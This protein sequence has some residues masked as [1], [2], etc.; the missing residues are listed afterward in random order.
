MGQV[1]RVAGRQRGNAR[2][3]ARVAEQREARGR[4]A[5]LSVAFALR[6]GATPEVRYGELSKALEGSEVTVARVRE[7]VLALRRAKGMVWDP[8]D[9]E[10]RTAGSCFM[11]PVGGGGVADAR[12]ARAGPGMGM[13]DS[14]FKGKICVA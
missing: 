9:P 6:R 14:F 12:G 4:Y 7:T 1:G 5:V 8:A 10:G 11:N 3:D 2:D 13:A